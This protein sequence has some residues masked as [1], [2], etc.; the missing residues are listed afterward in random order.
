MKSPKKETKKVGK[1]KKGGTVELS[2]L[3]AAGI[4]YAIGHYGKKANRGRKVRGGAEEVVATT[5][6]GATPVIYTGKPS[7]PTEV[8]PAVPGSTMPAGSIIPETVRHE[9]PATAVMVGS[10]SKSPL[11]TGGLLNNDIGATSASR[12][13]SVNTTGG[14]LQAGGGKKRKARKQKGGNDSIASRPPELMPV[15]TSPATPLPPVPSMASQ[16][17]GHIGASIP[18]GTSSGGKLGLSMVVPGAVGGVSG[19]EVPSQFGG[20]KKG[21]KGK[22]ST[23]GKKRGGAEDDYDSVD[24]GS[25]AEQEIGGYLGGA[26]NKGRKGTKGKKDKKRGGVDQDE[27]RDDEAESLIEDT[28]NMTDNVTFYYIKDLIMSTNAGS[29]SIGMTKKDINNI[30]KL[31]QEDNSGDVINFIDADGNDLLH[32]A[33]LRGFEDIAKAIEAKKN[34]LKESESKG[35]AKKDKKKSKG[36]AI[37]N[38]SEPEVS[39]ND[40]LVAVAIG[41]AAEKSIKE[42]RLVFLN[43]ILN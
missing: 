30:I 40:G 4:L 21:R 36:N 1:S 32:Y 17:C 11:V 22:K 10:A 26:K 16:S 43:E 19:Q 27:Y 3:A 14:L 35:G 23:K 31:I 37:K 34:E 18:P 20:A 15:S 6:G 8:K 12:P 39:L 42:G 29:R 33:N 13:A 38:K 28:R 24:G 41:E 2:P 5:P 9:N 7:V 25:S